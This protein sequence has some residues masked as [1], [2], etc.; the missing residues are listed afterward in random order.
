MSSGNSGGAGA[1][2]DLYGINNVGV[3]RTASA[4]SL[5][6]EIE[7]R[8]EE[9]KSLY[10]DPRSAI[11]PALYIAQE[12]FGFISQGAVTWVAARIGVPPVHVMEVATFYTMFYKRPVGKFHVQVCRTLSCAVRG[13]RRLTEHLAK[14]FG[15]APGEVTPDGIWSYEEVECLGSCGTAPMC[16]INDRYFENLTPERLDEI[17]SLIE[18]QHPALR[19]SAV[20]DSLGSGLGQFPLS[21]VVKP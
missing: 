14:R 15:I 3:N 8:I 5:G 17:L 11:L 7:R 10:P 9:L 4:P 18:E 16:E 6:E 2:E 21:E 1:D 12:H 13:A 19:F 20:D